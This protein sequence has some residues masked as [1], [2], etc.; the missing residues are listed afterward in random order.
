MKGSS[1]IRELAKKGPHYLPL[2]GSSGAYLIA[3]LLAGL[4]LFLRLSMA[5]ANAGWQYVTFFPAVTVAVVIV[6]FSIEAMHRYHQ[7]YLAELA[8]TRLISAQTAAINQ[9]LRDSE[10]F[11]LSVFDSRIDQVAVLNEHGIIMAVNE[12]WHRFAVENGAPRYGRRRHHGGI[13]GGEGRVQFGV[14][15]P[16]AHARALVQHA[17]HPLARRAPGRGDCP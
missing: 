1:Y 6:C 17:R 9:S 13:D 5:P 12:A 4:A 10:A 8:E 7:K 16:F 3:V 2:R 11:S 15:L 14:S